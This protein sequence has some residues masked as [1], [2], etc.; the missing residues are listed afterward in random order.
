MRKRS[1]GGGIRGASD[2]SCCGTRLPCG[3]PRVAS[4][5][6]IA[7]INR[8]LRAGSNSPRGEKPNIPADA[9]KE[10]KKRERKG[11]MRKIKR[12][13]KKEVIIAVI[14][15]TAVFVLMWGIR[16]WKTRPSAQGGSVGQ[17]VPV[18]QTRRALDGV[19]VEKEKENPAIAGVMIENVV[20]AQPLSGIAQA[21]QVFEAVTEANITR[22]LAYF[23]L[24]PSPAPTAVVAPS[25]AR[26]EGISGQFPSPRGRGEG[27]GN[28][29]IGP[30]RSARPYFL[31]WASEFDTLYGHVGSSPAAYELLRK[32]GVEGLY[33]FDQWYR[34][35]YFFTKAGRAKPHHL[36][37]SAELLGM[38]HAKELTPSNSPLERGRNETISSPLQGEV[39]RG[40]NSWQFKNDA[41][42]DLRGNVTDV[43][44]GYVAPYNVQWKYDSQANEY[45][46]L[47]WARPSTQGGSV[48]QGGPHKDANGKPIIAKNIAVA[49]M[50][51]KVLDKIG[52]KEFTT[53][54]EG[55]GLV[56]QDGRVVVGTWKKPAARERMRFYDG[57][58][59]EVLFN[60]GIT[61]VEIVPKGY[62]VKY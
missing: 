18:P 10:K 41:S 52:R 24:P 34:S 38:A 53:I 17:V 6:L 13:R 16:P 37:T 19:F 9:L 56:F 26:G 23:V 7:R 29:E 14:L 28:I 48:G 30:V 27:E 31:D 39:R 46:R 12:G 54:G 32:K 44:V 55:K 43:R 11:D 21:R 15:V 20:E 62:E 58:G 1:K 40:F 4:S 45:G 51:M 22:F 59:N 8:R 49:F 50:E 33:D 42:P 60:A 57:Q 36:Y 61:W 35:E 3:A 2:F 47:Q 25:P 5:R